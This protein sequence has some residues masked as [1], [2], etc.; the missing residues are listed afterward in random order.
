[1]EFGCF[2]ATHVSHVNKMDLRSTGRTYAHGTATEYRDKKTGVRYAK[3]NT[4]A[5]LTESNTKNC[6]EEWYQVEP[7]KWQITNWENLPESINPQGNGM[8][9]YVY[10]KLADQGR[11]IFTE[12]DSVMEDKKLFIEQK[13]IQ[14]VLNVPV[15]LLKLNH[16]E[17]ANTVT[18]FLN[19]IKDQELKMLL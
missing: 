17:H 6:A 11:E 19:N 3:Y 16:V 12:L 4:P 14:E 18:K 5:W 1:M 15:E 2:P 8:S 7:L 13:L 9:D 10:L